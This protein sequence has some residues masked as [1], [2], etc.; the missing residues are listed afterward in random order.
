MQL[1]EL[2]V[3][4]RDPNRVTV[5][6]RAGC[7]VTFLR[8]EDDTAQRVS[9]EIPSHRQSDI[10]PERYIGRGQL[11]NAQAKAAEHFRLESAIANVSKVHLSLFNT[12][13][14]RTL[15]DAG[16][17][18]R[19]TDKQLIGYASQ[20]LG[21]VRNINYE[22]EAL[23]K[24][25]RRLWARKGQETKAENAEKARKP[26]TPTERGRKAAQLLRAQQQPLL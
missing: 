6:L 12:W 13:L 1:S 8:M 20:W 23:T 3:H 7:S 11:Q 17:G 16:L 9:I 19:F 24:A 25:L 18:Y 22:P 5:K 2:Y 21:T 26:L 10:S 14:G 15:G 4:P